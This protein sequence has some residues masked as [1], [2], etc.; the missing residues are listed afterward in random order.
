MGKGVRK[1]IGGAVISSVLSSSELRSDVFWALCSENT[2][3]RLLCNYISWD[4]E[5]RGPEGNESVG[6]IRMALYV[7]SLKIYHLFGIIVMQ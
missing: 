2:E 3:L 6:C 1:E 7:I 4:V 5:Q